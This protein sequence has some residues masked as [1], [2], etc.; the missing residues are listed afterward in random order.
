MPT[1]NPENPLTA[2]F[3]ATVSHGPG[4]YQMLDRRELLYVGKARDLR[5]RLSQYAH[6]NGPAWSKTAVM[7]SR[8]LRVE[9]IL[10]TTE[11]EAL[12]LEAALIKKHHPRYNID[13]RDD[14]N[15]PLI[16]VSTAESWPRVSVTRRRLRDGNRYFGPYTAAG[17]MR[18]TLELLYAQFPL[19][20]CRSL[21]ERQRPCLNHQMGR[22]CAPCA[23]LVDK[24][25]YMRMVNGVL[26]I[27][28]G[29]TEELRQELETR[30]QAAAEALDFEQAARLRDRLLALAGTTERQVIASGEAL[31]QDVFGLHRKDASVGVALLFVRGGLMTGARQFFLD[32][33]I[34]DDGALLAQVL[35]QYYSATRQPPR[36]LLLPVLP[37]DEELVAEC[38]A[39]LR[40]GPVTFSVPQRGK[41][42]QLMQMAHANAEKLFSEEARK[43][44][45]WQNLATSIRQ[46]LRLSR[47]PEVIE[48]LDISNLLGKQAVGSLVCF[49]HG[50]KE[51]RRFRHYRI[52]EKETP[53]DYAMMREVLERRLGKGRN[54]HNLPDLLLLDGGK[55][56]LQVALEVVG[57]LGLEGEL[58]LAAIAEEHHDEGEKLFRPG[59]KDAIMLPAHAPALLYLM[60]VRDEAHRFGITCHRHLRGKAQLASALDAVPGVGPQ[61]KKQ[62]L[63]HFGSLRRIRTATESELAAAPGIGPELARSIVQAL[64]DRDAGKKA[65]GAVKAG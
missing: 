33:P 7:L 47:M 35:M 23:G 52:R 3:L 13:L 50:E 16:R 42:M 9:T 58:D 65:G 25:E 40:E 61:R 19:R 36:E 30:M 38:L 14:K 57:R 37:E 49:V 26:A 10:T 28:E 46:K 24:A 62:L 51:T 48:C 21:R 60:R 5:K 17:A 59:R 45:A 8:V 15:Y 56:Q 18:S 27:L 41:R 39:G 6:F 55:G 63:R 11:K 12:I 34:G 1:S 53:D 64:Q 44:A 31:D 29:K 22:C 54:E 43:E 2:E 32:D 4:V 20:H